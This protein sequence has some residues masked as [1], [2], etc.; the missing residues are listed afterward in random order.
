MTQFRNSQAIPNSFKDPGLDQSLSQ[1]SMHIQPNVWKELS[2]PCAVICG[3]FSP[4]HLLHTFKSIRAQP[5]VSLSISQN[6]LVRNIDA[7]FYSC[8]T[9]QHHTVVAYS[10]LKACHISH[11]TIKPSTY[12]RHIS[13]HPCDNFWQVL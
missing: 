6:T 7:P 3:Y 5:K 11:Q 2:V 12:L 1:D 9:K 13:H 8:T 10:F 4:L